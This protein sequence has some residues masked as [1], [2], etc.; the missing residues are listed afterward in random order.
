MFLGSDYPYDMGMMD[1]ARHVQALGLAD[2]DRD[3]I[4]G[5]HAEAILSKRRKG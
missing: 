1:C 2:R 3:M 4:L 5:G